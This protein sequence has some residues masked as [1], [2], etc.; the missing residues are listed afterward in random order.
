MI[1]ISVSDL[2]DFTL[3]HDRIKQ[4]QYLIRSL[5][6]DAVNYIQQGFTRQGLHKPNEWAPRM[7]PNLAGIFSD[8]NQPG[9]QIK[10]RRLESR[11]VLM[12]TGTLK[13]SI[14]SQ[15]LNETKA[16]IGTNVEYA[17]VQNEGGYSTQIR[18]NDYDFEKKIDK[19]IKVNMST[20]R[21]QNQVFVEY[22]LF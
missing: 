16:F 21:L 2:K 8:A 20:A 15:I 6:F 3:F 13:K 17:E 22:L 19:F 9:G 10:T 4:S 7:N 14:S 1:Y 18:T 12:D 11:P 5:A